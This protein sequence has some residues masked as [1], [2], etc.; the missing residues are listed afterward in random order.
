MQPRTKNSLSIAA[1]IGAA[2]IVLAVA[3]SFFTSHQMNKAAD[4]HAGS[5]G[6]PGDPSANALQE[7]QNAPTGRGPSTSGANPNS[8]V[9]PA[10][11]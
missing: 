10:S 1:F 9:P 5:A 6:R 11:R 8:S 2:F 4:E 7:Q 3:G